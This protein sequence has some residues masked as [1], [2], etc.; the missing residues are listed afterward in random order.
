MRLE[1]RSLCREMAGVSKCLWSSL[2]CGG[3]YIVPRGPSVAIVELIFIWQVTRRK[4]KQENTWKYKKRSKWV[5]PPP[6]SLGKT[7][8]LRIRAP[9]GLLQWS[10]VRPVA[11][12]RCLYDGNLDALQ[13]FERPGQGKLSMYF[14]EQ[15]NGTAEIAVLPYTALNGIYYANKY[16]THLLL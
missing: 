13:H 5:W 8:T 11:A 1:D 6:H 15:H 14:A 12:I 16:C 4:T 10:T 3:K 9:Y 7:H 2:W